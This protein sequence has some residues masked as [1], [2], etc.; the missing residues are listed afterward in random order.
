MIMTHEIYVVE[1]QRQQGYESYRLWADDQ[2]IGEVSISNGLT[3][4]QKQ[5]ALKEAIDEL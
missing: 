1:E 4:A 3:Q 2:C 5:Q